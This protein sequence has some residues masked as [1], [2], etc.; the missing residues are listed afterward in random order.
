M[1]EKTDWYPPEIKPV[2][3]GVYETLTA[4]ENQWGDAPHYNYWDGEDF[5]ISGTTLERAL[6]YKGHGHSLFTL[7]WRG[8]SKE[9]K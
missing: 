5:C 7:Y 6:L 3:V 1:E 8:L 4:E 9:P 2:R